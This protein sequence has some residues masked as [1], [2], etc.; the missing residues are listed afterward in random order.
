[1][2]ENYMKKIIISLSV[3]GAVAAIVIGATGAFFSDTETSSGNVFTAGTLDLKVDHLFASYDGNQ[4]TGNCVPIGNNLVLNGGFEAPV[5]VNGAKWD[6]FPSGTSGLGWTVEWY[7]GATSFG[8][9]TRPVIANLELHR[10][11][12]G[13]ADEGQQYAE[14][15]TDWY[16]PS[17]NTSGEPASVKI[18]QDIPTTIGKTYQLSFAFS[19]RPNTAAGENILDV[20]WGGSP[21]TTLGP[22]AGGGSISWSTYSYQVTATTTLTRVEFTD[23]GNPESDGTFLDAVDVHLMDCSSYQITG[24]TCK[25]WDLKDLG[26]GDYFWNFGDVKPGDYG[27][28]IISL[29]AYSNDAYACL[30]TNNIDD[31][32]NTLTPPEIAAGD[33]TAGPGPGSG[34][35]SQFIK[36]F[37][38]EDSNTN[39]AYDIGEN[40]LV[41]VN[42]PLTASTTKIAL[43]A[44]QTKDIGLAWCAGTQSLTGSTI[45]C[46]GSSVTNIAQTDITTANITA[47]AEQQRN[48]SGFDCAKVVLPPIAR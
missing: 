47:Y 37:V 15:D 38:W 4:C 40:I 24:G 33:T 41:P 7:D 11:V 3:I 23:L 2:R 34:E 46:D 26:T 36:I 45:S 31:E 13:P 25:L 44:S 6:I 14:L 10:G 22:V 30:F 8:G 12:L 39:N 48:N 35:L 28:N 9:D 16:G 20:K 21:V 18:Y 17:S 32:E 29:H 27:V 1:M 19:P 42:S 43:T 5:V